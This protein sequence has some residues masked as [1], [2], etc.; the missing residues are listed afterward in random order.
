LFAG[1]YY[2]FAFRLPHVF[3]PLITALQIVQLATVTWVWHITP[4]TCADNAVLATFPSAYPLEHAT[5]YIFVPVYF[6]F[7]VKFFVMT[8]V[9]PKRAVVKQ[10]AV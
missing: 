10:K 4:D 3:R 7:F 1:Q 5:P 2:H 9:C 8:Y 6:A